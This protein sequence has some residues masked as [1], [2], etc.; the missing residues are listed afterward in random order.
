MLIIDP[1]TASRCG[2]ACAASNVGPVTFTA[3]MSDTRL[4]VAEASGIGTPAPALLTSTS[5][6]PQS[7]NARSTVRGASS[8]LAA[9]ATRLSMLRCAAATAS[10]GA[11]RRPVMSTRAPFSAKA[12]TAERPMPELPPVMITTWFSYG[13]IVPPRRCRRKA[14]ANAVREWALRSFEE[15]P[16]RPNIGADARGVHPIITSPLAAG[17]AHVDAASGHVTGDPD[18]DVIREPEPA[19]LLTCLDVARIGIGGNDGPARHQF[20]DVKGL[21]ESLCHR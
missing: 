18:Y 11:L 19:A 14:S 15:V 7:A 21:V 9:S 1:F 20:R 5:K 10:N 8:G 2:A 6:R 4:A 13:L 12:S 16:K 17:R 3:K